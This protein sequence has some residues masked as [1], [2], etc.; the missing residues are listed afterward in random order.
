MSLQVGQLNLINCQ[1]DCAAEHAVIGKLGLLDTQTDS[2]TTEDSL[3][4]DNDME[5]SGDASEPS[6]EVSPE[7]DEEVNIIHTITD[8]R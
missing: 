6:L 3:Y 5:G 1:Y 2:T 7:D 8:R 4:F